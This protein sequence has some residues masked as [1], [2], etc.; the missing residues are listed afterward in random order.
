MAIEREVRLDETE[1]RHFERCMAAP[2]PTFGGGREA[3][4]WRVRSARVKSDAGKNSPDYSVLGFFGGESFQAGVL[5]RL[6][7]RLAGVAGSSLITTTGA[8]TTGAA[9]TGAAT[10]GS[11]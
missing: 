10:T 3:L 11:R 4:D 5:A 2:A 9:T 8:A 1:T 7:W 6:D